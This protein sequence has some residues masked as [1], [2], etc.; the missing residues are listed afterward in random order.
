M[1]I[2]L[3]YGSILEVKGNL[4]SDFQND[5]VRMALAALTPILRPVCDEIIARPQVLQAFTWRANCMSRRTF[6]S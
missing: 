5:A 2:D 3:K 4:R 6:S 1:N